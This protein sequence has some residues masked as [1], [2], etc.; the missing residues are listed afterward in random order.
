MSLVV[1]ER[2]SDLVVGLREAVASID[3]AALSGSDAVELVEMFSEAE[4]LAAAGKTIAAGRVASSG[5]WQGTGYRTPAQWIASRTQSTVGSAI[6]TLETARNL[7]SLPST[8][9]SFVSGRLS[10]KQAAEISAASV[11][12]PA[13]EE[14]LLTTAAETT[15][16]QLKEECRQV[17]MAAVSDEDAVERI[18]LGRYVRSWVDRDGA[19]RLDARLAPDDGAVLMGTVGESAATLQEQAR[20]SGRQERAEAYAADALVGLASREGMAPRAVVHVD[21]DASAFV[22]GRTIAGERC[23][24][25]GIG[26]VPV[27]V[28]RRMASAGIVKVIERDGVDVRRVVHRGRTIPAHLRTALE[29]RDEIC[30][31]PGC[32]VRSNLEIDHLLPYAEGG[33]TQLANLARLCRYHHAQ[34]TH[35]G[36]R[37]G[38]KPGE[39]TWTRG[40]RAPPAPIT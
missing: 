14:L 16:A 10:E 29:A 27:T 25:A 1:C 18:R 15:V 24:I 40:G 28:A 34:K 8:R 39:W 37:L 35:H 17:R 11:I 12:D 7:D 13:A 33:P 38:G 2:V 3:V 9:E 31:V 22:R 23:R 4:R 32:D 5:A 36:W 30:V 19:V 21:V 20:R 6:T 26:A